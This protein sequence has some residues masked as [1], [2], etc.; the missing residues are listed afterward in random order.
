MYFPYRQI[1]SHSWYAPR[2]LVVR[3]TE[4]PVNLAN[5]I[6]RE[7]YEVD[8]NQPVSNIATM[9]EL[10]IEET[11][12]RRLG[13]I[14][15]TTYA[16]LALLL[17]ALGIYGVLSHFVA[18]QTPE[19]GIR[20]ALGAERWDILVMVIK[21]GMRWTLLGIV[22]GTLAALALT[23]LMANLLFGI[24]ATDPKTFALVPLL[25][26]VVAFLACWIPARRATKVD[27]MVALRYE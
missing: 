2:D 25:L 19:I 11:G 21:K 8:P 7:I 1:T 27:P 18:Q 5:A 24:S 14:L 26:I 6:R 15:L 16:G 17:S 9:D 12:P 20:A 3:T 10:L 23:R 13:S 22:I 4:D